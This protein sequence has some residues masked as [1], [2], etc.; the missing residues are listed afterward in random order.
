MSRP[1]SQ[2]GRNSAENIMLCSRLGVDAI[3][4]SPSPLLFSNFVIKFIKNTRP[5]TKK[6]RIKCED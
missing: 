2:A 4:E 6:C 3:A 5:Y 1:L